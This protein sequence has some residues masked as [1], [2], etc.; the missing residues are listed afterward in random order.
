MSNNS[1][2]IKCPHCEKIFFD[3]EN[4]SCPFCGK[5]LNDNLDIFKDLFGDNNPFDGIGIT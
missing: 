1:G 2:V 5:K 3:N 4:K